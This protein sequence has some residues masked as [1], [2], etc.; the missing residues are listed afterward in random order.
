[1][2]GQ[3]GKNELIVV[4]GAGGFIGGWLVRH[5]LEAGH[6]QVRAVDLKPALKSELV[7]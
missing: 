6:R 1:M 5:L 4:T 7:P 2:T 3:I